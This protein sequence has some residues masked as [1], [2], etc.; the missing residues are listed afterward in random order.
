M[1]KRRVIIIAASQIIRVG[2]KS[3]LE[4]ESA[5]HVV[6]VCAQLG[7]DNQ[8]FLKLKPDVMLICT[9]LIPCDGADS[10]ARFR[11]L[12]LHTNV[13]AI[14]HSDSDAE[15]IH[16]IKAGVRACFSKDMSSEKMVKS[17]ELAAS[18]EVIISSMMAD[19]LLREFSLLERVKDTGQLI[20][21]DTLGKRE[22]EVLNLVAQGL[23]NREIADTLFISEQTVMVHMKN[24]MRKLHA[25]TRT[26]AVAFMRADRAQGIIRKA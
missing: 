14:C 25:H 9:N 26:Q 1:S 2:L 6:H 16:A 19:A 3:M 23:T 7:Q 13:I 18:G 17:I 24:I 10:I 11:E 21:I 5:I 22:G 12:A 15:C 4:E 8:Q 20:N